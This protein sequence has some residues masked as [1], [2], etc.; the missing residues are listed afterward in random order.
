MKTNLSESTIPSHPSQ[1]KVSTQQ[2]KL[3]SST[4]NLYTTAE[5]SQ[6][7]NQVILPHE[8]VRDHHQVDIIQF[9]PEQGDELDDDDDEEEDP[10]DDLDV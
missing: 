10:D 4:F 1:S 7:R 2:E 8:Q 6:M 5:Q 9:E 3:P